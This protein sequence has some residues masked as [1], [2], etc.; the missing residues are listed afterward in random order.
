MVNLTRA[1]INIL[2]GRYIKSPDLLSQIS[3]DLQNLPSDSPLGEYIEQLSSASGGPNGTI[4]ENE[5]IAIGPDAQPIL[6]AGDT[7]SS[8]INAHGL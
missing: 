3:D 1:Q 6:N 7:R 2:L 5:N 8:F 4:S